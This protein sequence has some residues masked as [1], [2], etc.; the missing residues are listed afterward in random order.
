M[1]AQKKG[2]LVLSVA[3]LLLSSCGVEDSTWSYSREDMS[4]FASLT[5][6]ISNLGDGKAQYDVNPGVEILSRELTKDDVIVYDI[7][8][9]AEIMATYNKSYADHAVIK[10]ASTPVYNVTTS[11]DKCGFKVDFDWTTGVRYGMMVTSAATSTSEF[12]VVEPYEEEQTIVENDPQAQ[13]E[14]EYVIKDPAW[15][16][17]GSQVYSVITNIGVI[18]VAAFA[19]SPVSIASGIFGILGTIF[20]AFSPSG[21]SIQDVLN[22]LKEIDTKIDELADALR[23]NTKQ[24]E[25]DILYND[26]M[27]NADALNNLT[28]TLNTFT[29]NFLSPLSDINRN[30]G[31]QFS[32]LFKDYVQNNQTVKL[33]L[34][35]NSKDE[36]ESVPHGEITNANY[37][38]D[39]SFP[40]A[41]AFITTHKTVEDGFM[42]ELNADIENSINRCTDLPSGIDKEVLAKFILS[43]IEESF[44]QKYYG[45]GSAKHFEEAQTYRNDMV[46]LAQRISGH[47]GWTSIL[48]S[49]LDRLEYMYNFA[50]E[51]K[52]VVRTICAN[53]LQ[54]LDMN[55][56]KAGLAC[57]YAGINSKEMIDEY[58]TARENIQNLYKNIK[59]VKDS[60]SFT[61]GAALTG[62]FYRA[63]YS[64]SYSNPGNHCKLDVKFDFQKVSISGY[65][66]VKF[67]EDNISNHY[68]L[69]YAQQTHLTT[70]WN[71]LRSIGQADASTDYIHYLKNNNVVS[72]SGLNAYNRLIDMGWITNDGYRILLNDRNERDLNSSDTSL[73]MTCVAKGNP[74][75]D[76]YSENGHYHYREGHEAD[77]WYGKMYEGTYLDAATGG[78]MGVGKIAAWAR[79][80]EDHWYWSDDEYWAF[81]DNTSG[82]YFFLVDIATA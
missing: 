70:R 39:L 68:S 78:S 64:P 72:D 37:S 33:Q 69:S 21:P 7:N 38:F 49:Y 20:E 73:G 81:I 2:L 16:E 12:I 48:T 79:Y 51:I 27:V 23:R 53:L 44:F 57:E 24:I 76:Y 32:I 25:D 46:K 71:L 43:D 60:Y 5:G 59:E 9:A 26:A 62:D 11:E 34:S 17:G 14:E 4:S 82:N 61:T 41:K 65:Y 80:A 29:T 35:K 52:P 3:A 40:K 10:S 54:V 74:G 47:N 31:D 75:G 13:F 18:V 56:A 63:K 58:K 1:K 28:E 42:D 22:K 8:K 55:V 77:S 19:A 45:D 67:D 36:W 6:E 66:T 30:L 50:K 15:G